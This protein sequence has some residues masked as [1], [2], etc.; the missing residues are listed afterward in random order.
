MMPVAQSPMEV[1]RPLIWLRELNSM[2]LTL[3]MAAA[4]TVAAE[5][6]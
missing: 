4:M 6:I 1:V 3:M 5:M 2:E